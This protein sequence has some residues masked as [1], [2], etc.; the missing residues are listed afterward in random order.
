MSHERVEA[1]TDFA[2]V[3][4]ALCEGLRFGTQVWLQRL[5][6]RQRHDGVFLGRR[7]SRA[8][9][10]GDVPLRNLRRVRASAQRRRGDFVAQRCVDVPRSGK[11]VTVFGA[12]AGKGAVAAWAR[13]GDMSG[14]EGEFDTSG[15][16]APRVAIDVDF[17][18][19]VGGRGG[20]LLLYHGE[21]ECE[22]PMPRGVRCKDGR[23]GAETR[24][25]IAAGQ[26]TK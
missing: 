25:A 17:H 16:C 24:G 20:H 1:T 2:H 9:G 3:E 11:G 12:A 18:T 23:V 15:R 8:A 14:D 22:I 5:V 6:P 13:V 21:V 4:S 10:R 19:D 26:G 7:A